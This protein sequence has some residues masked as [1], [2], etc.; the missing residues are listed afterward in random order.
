MCTI[1]GS[2]VDKDLI[3]LNTY[4][5]ILKTL[6]DLKKLDPNMTVSEMIVNAKKHQ[7]LIIQGIK[8][9]SPKK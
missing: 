3:A 5:Q 8:E 6:E 4:T 9:S 1:C 7:D 2:I